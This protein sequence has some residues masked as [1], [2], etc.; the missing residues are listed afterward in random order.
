MLTLVSL[1]AAGHVCVLL[2]PNQSERREEVM[3]RRIEMTPVR[4]KCVCFCAENM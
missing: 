4:T 3:Q 1:N 2:Q